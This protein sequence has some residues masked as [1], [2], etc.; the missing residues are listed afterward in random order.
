MNRMTPMLMVALASVLV[1][2][3]VA[4][5]QPGGNPLFGCS[6]ADGVGSGIFMLVEYGDA[7][8][9]QSCQRECGFNYGVEPYFRGGDGS[10]R[11]W[12]YTSCI[13]DCNRKFWKDY[14]R[15]MRNLEEETE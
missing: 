6:T 8:D 5:A 2:A 12:M 7:A 9:L 14:D 10:A 11:W 13:Q 1:F 4:A 3:G 15:K